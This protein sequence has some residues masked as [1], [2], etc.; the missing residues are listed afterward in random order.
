MTPSVGNAPVASVDSALAGGLQLKSWWEERERRDDYADRFGL[1]RSFNP[2]LHDAEHGRSPAVE[3]SHVEEAI[4]VAGNEIRLNEIVLSRSC[5]RSDA[6][7][8]LAIPHADQLFSASRSL[9][10]REGMPP[11]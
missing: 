11:R 8:R 3:G 4:T 9:C 6:R 7:V 2:F 10:H 5:P 1:R